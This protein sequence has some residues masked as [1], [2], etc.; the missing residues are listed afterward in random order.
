LSRYSS[1][2]TAAT[3]KQGSVSVRYAD[4]TCTAIALNFVGSGTC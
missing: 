2:T 3:M 4:V 1:K